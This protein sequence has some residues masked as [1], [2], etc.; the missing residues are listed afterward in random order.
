LALWGTLPLSILAGSVMGRSSS[1]L[2]MSV[3]PAL[4]LLVA[5]PLAALVWV[6]GWFEPRRGSRARFLATV[7]G[8]HVLALV[9]GVLSNVH[10]LSPGSL[11]VFVLME[12][13]WLSAALWVL[14]SR[15]A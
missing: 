5:V 10:V 12:G 7:L 3:L 9:L 4:L 15:S 13:L 6:D 14:S 8:L 2:L 11:A 1:H